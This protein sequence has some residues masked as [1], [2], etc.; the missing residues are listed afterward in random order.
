MSSK[1]M[2]AGLRVDVDTLRGTR[3]GVPNLLALFQRYGIRASFFF[4]VGPDNMG[5]HL[6]RLLRPSFLT[7]MIRTGAPGLYGWEI[8]LN[9]TFRPG[10]MIGHQAATIIRR[11][12]KAGHEIGL[13]CWDHHQWQ[14][15]I[16]SMSE[17]EIK[18]ITDRAVHLLTEITGQP[19]RCMAAPAWR[20]T[21]AVLEDRDTRSLDYCS[22]CRGTSIFYPQAGNKTFNHPQIPTTL[23]TYDELIGQQGISQ[24]TYNATLLYHFHARQLNTLTIHAEAEGGVCLET[25]REFLKMARERSIRF[26]PLGSFLHETPPIIAAPVI[27]GTIQ[28]RDGWISC[29]GTTP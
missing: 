5:R 20:L 2:Q 3:Q 1:T 14:S 6:L 13:H 21:P 17:A 4:S 15:R 9:G 23:P 12:A 29:Q 24:A 8:L 26:Q 22:D 19:V 11:T 10:P 16:H 25:F 28:G 27:R 7:K 18:S